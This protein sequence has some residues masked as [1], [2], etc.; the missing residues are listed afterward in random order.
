VIEIW[1]SIDGFPGYEVS[2]IGRVKSFRRDPKGELLKPYLKGEKGKKT[3]YLRV[4]LTNDAGVQKNVRV[5]RI[6]LITFSGPPP[7]EKHVS[8]HIDGN[9]MN[10]WLLNLK[11]A[12]QLENEKH[13]EIH[14]TK[15]IGTKVHNS[16]LT[17]AGV[18]RIRRVNPKCAADFKMLM[19]ALGVS[20]SAIC[21]VIKG[22]TW[23]HIV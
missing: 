5:N 17:P 14:G 2:N 6:V 18:R 16:K 23:S 7:S 21:D 1:K 20:R 3:D 10:N 11:W 15:P 12:T 8:C 19:A 4:R 9:S 22:R 13:K